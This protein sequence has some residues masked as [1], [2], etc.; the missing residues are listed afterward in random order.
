MILKKGNCELQAIMVHYR[1]LGKVDS[2][3]GGPCIGPSL[4][5]KS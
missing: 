2:I 3:V 1:K 4:H 5:T